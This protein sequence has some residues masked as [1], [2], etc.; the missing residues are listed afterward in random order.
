MS[1]NQFKYNEKEKVKDIRWKRNADIIIAKIRDHGLEMDNCLDVGPRSKL[2]ELLEKEFGYKIE[3]TA[4]DLDYFEGRLTLYDSMIFSHTLEH[5][6]NPLTALITCHFN[7]RPKG[8]MIIT[9]PQRMRFQKGDAHF[10]EIDHKRM[11]ALLDKAGFKI[12]EYTKINNPRRLREIFWR[13][14]PMLYYFKQTMGVYVVE[15]KGGERGGIR[16]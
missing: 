4:H 7:L 15:R 13:I 8:K 1:F 12:I 3:N 16:A 5:L 14:R 9:L 11:I 6:M 10:H 2:T